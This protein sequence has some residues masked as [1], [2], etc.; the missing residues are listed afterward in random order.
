MLE[1]KTYGDSALLINF[2]QKIEVH[3]NEEVIRLYKAIER[4]QLP[5]VRY[6]IPAYCSITLAYDPS[7]TDFN[8]LVQAIEELHKHAKK[9]SSETSQRRLRIPVCYEVP[10]AMDFEELSQQT[11]L[12]KK[13]IIA[14]HC[15]IE[16]RV[17]M[18]GFIPG[19][20]YMGKLPEKLY[21]ERKKN[22]RLRVPA[23]S[24]GLAGLQT[25]IYPAEA[26]GGWQI[27][28]RTPLKIFD[29][30][31]PR[32]F[33]FQAGDLVQFYGIDSTSFAEMAAQVAAGEFNLEQII[34]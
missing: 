19:F 7:Q 28:G 27:I 33:L 2:D 8:R 24:V 6:G 17:F 26:P 22:P 12:S 16:F 10:Y 14:I 21:C 13:E 3:I 34:S 32:S 9:S 29:P 11:K 30:E 20:T 25:G 18:L 31:A 4:A 23:C 15:E 5:G 1:F